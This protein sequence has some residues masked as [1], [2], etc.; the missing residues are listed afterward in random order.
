MDH[1]RI[2]YFSKHSAK[3]STKGDVKRQQFEIFLANAS[4]IGTDHLTRLFFPDPM[5]KE[6]KRLGSETNL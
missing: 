2:A 5:S 6:K 4:W 3:C 1:I